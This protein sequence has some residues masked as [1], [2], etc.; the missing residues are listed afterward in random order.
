MAPPP[1]CILHPYSHP[2]AST[3][4]YRQR[5]KLVGASKGVQLTGLE[6]TRYLINIRLIWIVVFHQWIVDLSQ[7]PLHPGKTGTTGTDEITTVEN[8]S[9][10]GITLW[11]RIG[12]RR[13]L[14]NAAFVPEKRLRHPPSS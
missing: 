4:L 3:H 1:R 2:I 9:V 6:T 13:G 12:E 8:Q 5:R 7:P 14:R 11:P 10:R